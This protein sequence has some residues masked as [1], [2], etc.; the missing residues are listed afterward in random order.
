MT[1]TDFIVSNLGTIWT[2][3]PLTDG[4]RGHAVEHFPAETPTFGLAYAVEHR[5]A[6]DIVTALLSEGFA[7]EVDGHE[8]ELPTRH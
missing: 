6:P 3:E 4:A 2:F 1:K 7:V 5:F 8:V